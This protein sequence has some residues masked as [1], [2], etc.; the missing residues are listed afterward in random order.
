VLID[1]VNIPQTRRGGEFPQFDC[2]E[3]NCVALL[4]H[5]AGAPGIVPASVFQIE[6]WLSEHGDF[7]GDGT[8]LALGAACLTA[9]GLPSHVASQPIDDA[10][11]RSHYSIPLVLASPQG[12]PLAGGPDGHYV[13]YL[14]EGWYR[15]PANGVLTNSPR[16]AP[17]Y[18][19]QCI[20][21]DVDANHGR[22]ADDVL[23]ADAKN[24][25]STLISLATLGRTTGDDAS[26]A[27][28]IENDGTN[29][30]EIIGEMLRTEE[31]QAWLARVN[32]LKH[33]S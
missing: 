24:G 31:S 26:R 8:P 2:F 28:R 21:I 14:G 18:T 11:G 4:R 9:H 19:G 23:S 12:I 33:S 32:Q 13:T 7:P 25:I 16:L 27:A 22:E 1:V 30:N 15:N 17:A 10:A 3:E 20:E 6:Q 5:F 29:I